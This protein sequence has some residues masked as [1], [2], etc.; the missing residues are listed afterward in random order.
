MVVKSQKLDYRIKGNKSLAIAVTDDGKRR[1]GRYLIYIMTKAHF[2][3]SLFHFLKIPILLLRTCLP[4]T[5]ICVAATT[6]CLPVYLLLLPAACLLTC[7]YYYHLC[8]LLL[9]SSCLS[10]CYAYLLLLPAY[11]LVLPDCLFT[12]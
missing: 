3:Y 12:C 8:S 2:Y 7:Y 4:A 5:T 6:I 9:L 11:L 10:I 1:V